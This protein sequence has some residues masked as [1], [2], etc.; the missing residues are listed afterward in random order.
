MIWGIVWL[1]SF[2]LIVGALLPYPH[3]FRGPLASLAFTALTASGLA[4]SV[5]AL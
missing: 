2:T 5:N 4:L 1:A 3:T